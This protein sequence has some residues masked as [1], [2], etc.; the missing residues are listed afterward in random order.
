[1]RITPTVPVSWMDWGGGGAKIYRSD[2]CG[3]VLEVDDFASVTLIT[4]A[5]GGI[6][7]EIVRVL[8]GI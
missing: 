1:M 8:H 7:A 5:S 3:T 6:G 2:G 4:G